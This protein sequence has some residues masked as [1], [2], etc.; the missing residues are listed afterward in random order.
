MTRAASDIEVDH[1][2]STVFS[3]GRIAQSSRYK[4]IDVGSLAP[5]GHVVVI[6][7]FDSIR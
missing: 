2:N 7:T 1:E 5:I 3:V 4:L 6:L